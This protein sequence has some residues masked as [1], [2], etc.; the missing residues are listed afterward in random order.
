MLGEHDIQRVG[1]GDR[2]P[3]L[4]GLAEQWANLRP[5]E[6]C[7]LEHHKRLVDLCRRNGVV[8]RG[9]PERSSHFNE[10]V[11]WHPPLGRRRKLSGHRP[12]AASCSEV[13][14]RPRT[15]RG[16]V[17]SR[18]V[19]A[20]LSDEL[21]SR[22]VKLDWRIDEELAEPRV[23]GFGRL[24]DED[25]HRISRQVVCASHHG[26][27]LLAALRPWSQGSSTALLAF[28]R[29]SQTGQIPR[30][31]A[32][33][34]PDEV[35]YCKAVHAVIIAIC[36]ATS[37]VSVAGGNYRLHRRDS[38]RVVERMAIGAAG[39][40]RSVAVIGHRLSENDRGRGCSKLCCGR[41]IERRGSLPFSPSLLQAAGGG[42][43]SPSKAVA[44]SARATIESGPLSAEVRV[45]S[46]SEGFTAVEKIDAENRRSLFVAE[47]GWTMASGNAGLVARQTTCTCPQRCDQAQRPTVG[48]VRRR[49]LEWTTADA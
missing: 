35:G 9:T 46:E 21:R 26:S 31:M 27:S 34:R 19:N 22:C 2:R 36:P 43:P 4:P 10:V 6:Y 5:K 45:S 8:Q 49:R 3:T 1:N 40:L 18:L 24:L 30:P 38:R 28:D 14:R 42:N 25:H 33:P 48:L 39:G 7:P 13:A 44:D 37:F 23:K 17:A 11:L 16:R 29:Q 32:V 12:C 15:H 47:D 20:S 41:R